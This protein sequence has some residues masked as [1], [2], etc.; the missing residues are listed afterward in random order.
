MTSEKSSIARCRIRERGLGT[1][2]LT[3]AAEA[4]EFVIQHSQGDCRVALNALENAATLARKD[5][6]SRNQPESLTG[7]PAA[8]A[9]SIR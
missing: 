5:K 3:L 8:Q 9:A 4:R 1:W 2:H 6:N 7:S